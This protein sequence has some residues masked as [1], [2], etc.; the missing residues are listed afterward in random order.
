VPHLPLYDGVHA[1]DLAVA[2]VVGV[3]AAFIVSAVRSLG[4]G[5]DALHPRLGMA[6]L[7][8]AGGFAVGALA[9]IADLLG[10]NSQDVLFSG[11]T[12][13]P[14][15]ADATSTKVVVILLVAK[16]LAYGV[17]LGC[18]YRGGPIFPAV[19]LGVAL[20]AFPVAWFD[21]SPT[22]AIA[23]GAAAG[24]AAQTNL[25][26]SPVLFGALLVGSQGADAV[27]AAV[28]ATAAAWLTMTALERRRTPSPSPA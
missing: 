10:D 21:A 27:P 1:G 15:V 24:M 14:A 13:I 28:I 20:M 2:L 19:F 11:Q 6:P 4:T 5:V 9:E 17:S 18:G 8:L 7:L 3:G 23:V 12:S 26:I 22:L 16:F 25:L